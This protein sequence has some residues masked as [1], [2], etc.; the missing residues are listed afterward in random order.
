MDFDKNTYAFLLFLLRVIPVHLY[1][2]TFDY[3]IEPIIM[4]T[5]QVLKYVHSNSTFP[6][7]KNNLCM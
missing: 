6:E 2:F 3:F 1:I 4:L 7:F 5:A